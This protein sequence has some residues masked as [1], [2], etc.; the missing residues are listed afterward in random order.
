[1]AK[2]QFFGT[3]GIRG[4]AGKAPMDAEFV[5]RLGKAAGLVLGGK[6]SERPTFVGAIRA[7]WPMLQSALVAGL[8]ASGANVVDLGVLLPSDRLPDPKTGA[9]A[10]RGHFGFA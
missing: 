5:L 1:M 2:P 3:D 7:L 8:L 9:Q 10:W 4:T 6:S